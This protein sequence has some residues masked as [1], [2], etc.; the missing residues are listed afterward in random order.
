MEEEDEKSKK[1]EEEPS[2]R[3]PDASKDVSVVQDRVETPK[4]ENIDVIGASEA[5]IGSND[6][7]LEGVDS[8]IRV[9][10][11]DHFEH[12]SLKDQDIGRFLSGG[13]EEA[14]HNLSGA[15]EDE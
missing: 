13:L 14:A 9:E 4:K 5:E 8:A 6:V 12:V 10:N 3:D 1:V 15:H 7:P 2:M 11:E